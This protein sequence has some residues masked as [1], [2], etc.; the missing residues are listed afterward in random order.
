MTKPT[1]ILAGGYAFDR[2]AVEGLSDRLTDLMD[3]YL[4]DALDEMTVNA[5]GPGSCD[6]EDYFHRYA[7]AR[8]ELISLVLQAAAG[9]ELE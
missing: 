8:G 6:D 2:V 7:D 3:S 1:E 4:G 5:I 9:I